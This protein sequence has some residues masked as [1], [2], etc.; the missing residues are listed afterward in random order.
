MIL[1]PDHLQIET[2]N[3]R[4]SSNCTM[5]TI[6][7]WKRKPVIMSFDTFKKILLKFDLFKK[8]MSY[9]TLQ[10]C[11]EPLL[12]NNI[13][14]KVALASKLG[15][16]GIGFASNCTELNEEISTKLLEA[17]LNTI[18][19]SIDGI[20]KETHE[21]IR[22]GTDFDTVVANSKRFIKLRDEMD[23]KTKIMPRFIIQETNKAEYPLFKETWS[24][25]LN[26]EKGDQI[27]K[28]DVHNWA[29]SVKDYENKDINVDKELGGYKCMWV[30]ERI[31]INSLGNVVLPCIDAHCDEDDG[32]FNYGNALIEDPIAIYNSE[33]MDNYRRKMM[34][35][36]IL[37]L[38]YCCTCTIPRSRAQGIH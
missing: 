30:F 4:C 38:D 26:T 34:D 20:K 32:E 6:N 19:F 8:Y 31:F 17:G 22:I 10:G 29:A 27:L 18:I 14:K 37:D 23:Y 2:I 13:H 9:L 11:G 3:G 7:Q 21:S 1:I 35:G 15:F 25:L 36:K 28:F 24:K 12:D 16:N 5:C 33:M